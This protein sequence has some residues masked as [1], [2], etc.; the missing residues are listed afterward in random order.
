MKTL[1][2][3][4]MRIAFFLVFQYVSKQLRLRIT[5]PKAIY[6]LHY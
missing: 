6:N 4:K 1:F 2:L 3:R 5:R